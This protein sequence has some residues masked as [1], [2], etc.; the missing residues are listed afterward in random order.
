MHTCWS[1]SCL[2]NVS[3]LRSHVINLAILRGIFKCS[4]EPNLLRLIWMT[5]AVTM[6]HL[7][8]KTQSAFPEQQYH[9]AVVMRRCDTYNDTVEP[10]C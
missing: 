9:A 5:F 10:T 3:M 8:L 4:A 7:V 1:R 2:V 6:L